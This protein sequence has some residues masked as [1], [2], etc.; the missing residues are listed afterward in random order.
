MISTTVPQI[1]RSKQSCPSCQE[2][3][4]TT[5]D[6]FKTDDLMHH[7]CVNCGYDFFD[8]EQERKLREREERNPGSDQPWNMGFV[9]I[10]AMVITI[11]IIALSDREA[12][13]EEPVNQARLTHVGGQLAT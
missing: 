12:R 11:I 7:H 2:H 3:F 5:N 6:S 9:L 13:R 8:T 4:L 10:M 1:K